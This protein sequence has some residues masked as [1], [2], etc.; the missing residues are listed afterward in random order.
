MK[1]RLHDK[2]V[3]VIILS[4]LIV[5]SVLE[6]VFRIGCMRQSLLSTTNTGE[7]LATAVFAMI[8]IAF[9]LAEKQRICYIC[10]G[11]WLACFTLDQVFAL[12]G[13]FVNVAVNLFN[14]GIV[15]I[16]IRLVAM[17]CIIAIGALLVEYLDDGTI[18]NSAFNTL[19]II[20]VVLLVAD[21]ALGAYNIAFNEPA[22][23][24]EGVE[25]SLFKKQI[26]LDIFNKIYY[27][28][29]IILFTFFAYNSAK[30]QLERT[31]LTK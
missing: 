20:A 25:L 13:M 7:P 21:I 12:P 9:T 31:N 23:L 11:A 18:C 4:V 1:K 5:V 16:M 22:T 29:M 19:C 14:P 28:I 3:G 17:I 10:Y 27:V 15:S 8:L 30:K 6:V 24:P 2:T 26:M